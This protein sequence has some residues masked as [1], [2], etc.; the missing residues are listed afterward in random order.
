[1]LPTLAAFRTTFLDED[2]FLSFLNIVV[3]RICDFNRMV[4]LTKTQFRS[5]PF[6]FDGALFDEKCQQV[7]ASHY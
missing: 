6:Q 1:M 3:K 5:K 2:N 4:S 7:L